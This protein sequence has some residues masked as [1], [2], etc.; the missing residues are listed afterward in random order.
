MSSRV[1]GLGRRTSES[2]EHL[3]SSI[4][5]RRGDKYKRFG[6]GSPSDVDAMLALPHLQVCLMVMTACTQTP[7][8]TCL[9][10]Q[11]SSIIILPLRCR[12]LS[13]NFW[14]TRYFFTRLRYHLIIFQEG[15]EIS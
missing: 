1:I 6:E 8:G 10:A 9:S 11:C 7:D 4:R 3:P 5:A 14:Y 2:V 13:V 12:F 15:G